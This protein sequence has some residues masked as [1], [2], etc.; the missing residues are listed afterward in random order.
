[1]EFFSIESIL[2]FF[3]FTI[4]AIVSYAVGLIQGMKIGKNREKAAK[5]QWNTVKEY[6]ES[7][8]NLNS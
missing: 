2:L 3:G 5:Y 6:K 1:M 8:K 7:L 4:I